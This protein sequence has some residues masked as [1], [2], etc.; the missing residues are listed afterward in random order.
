S[1]AGPRRRLL[2]PRPR[3]TALGAPSSCVLAIDADASAT[4]RHQFKDT[5][6]VARTGRRAGDGDTRRKILDAARSSFANHGYQGATIR[7]I[8]AE[9]QVDPALIHHYF[10]PKE[11]LFAASIEFPL[12]PANAVETI[13]ADGIEN[14]GRNLVRLF[15]S[16]WEIQPTRDAL[17]AIV[18]AGVTTDQGAETLRQFFGEV[19]LSHVAPHLEGEDAELRVALVASHLIGMALLRYVVGFEQLAKASPDELV[20]LITP[21]IQDYLTG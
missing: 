11:D 8:A 15:L 4:P 12:S 6:L 7:V 19:L 13:M 3:R 20:D 17:M 21:R 16:V 9:A 5:P 18:R 1:L 14:A 2:R 10:G